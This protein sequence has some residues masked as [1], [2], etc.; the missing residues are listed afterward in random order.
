MNEKLFHLGNDVVEIYRKIE[1]LKKNELVPVLFISIIEDIL[2][3]LNEVR[4]ELA[5]PKKKSRKKN[6]Q[7]KYNLKL[8]ISKKLRN[9]IYEHNKLS[10]LRRN[11]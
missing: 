2:H 11:S 4:R 6:L 8:E 3:I 7:K 10:N 5:F 9:S 1:K